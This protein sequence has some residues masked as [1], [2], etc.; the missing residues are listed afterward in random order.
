MTEH[1]FPQLKNDRILRA[2]RGEPVDRVPVWVMRQA[3]RYLPEFQEVRARHD[4]FT[5]CQTSAL[6]SQVT[7]QPILRFDLDASIIFSDILVIPQAMGLKVEMVAGIGPVLPQPL[8]NPSDLARLVR[9]NVEEALK[10]VGDAITLTRHK[11][12]G[13]VP[14]I[15]F[16]GAPWTLM[17]YMIQGGGSSTMAKARSWLY[18]YPEDSHKLLQMITDV[19]VDYLI[20]QVK[21]G[22][23]LLQVFESNGDYLDDTLFTNYSF[24]YLKQISKRVREQLKKENIP[25]VPMIVFPKGATMKSLE[26][27]AKDQSYEVIGLDWT[28]DP[29]EARK[30]LGPNVTLQGNMDPCAMYSSQDEIV[31]RAQ[32]M[33]VKFG[34]DRYIANLG[35]GILPDTPIPSMQAFIKG[36]HT[37]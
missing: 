20:M 12:D 2:A 23:Q 22:A 15:G 25:E 4:F 17:G 30:C 24:K 9:P 1:K 28:I 13:K 19:I 32:K 14:L 37:A 3:G 18:K 31:D 33:V 34:K 8:I 26:I 16:S 6:A 21:A 36:V 27:L 29:A 7:L 11:L 5:V 35:H 10:Y